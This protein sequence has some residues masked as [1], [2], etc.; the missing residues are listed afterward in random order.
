MFWL[1]ATLTWLFFAALAVACGL[2][3]V[4]LLEPLVGEAAAHVAGTLAVCALL[5][6]LMDR[7]VGRLVP[8]AAPRRKVRLLALGLFWTALTVA[9]EFGFGHYAMGHSWQRLL[10]DYNILAGRVWVLVL[11]TMYAG[12]RLVARWR[13]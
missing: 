7:F 9:F 10:A 2:L 8:R 13:G 3:R 12:P 4:R 6:C 1:H 5:L 11:L